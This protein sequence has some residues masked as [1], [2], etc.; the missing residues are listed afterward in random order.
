MEEGRAAVPK[1]EESRGLAKSL[2]RTSRSPAV[3]WYG[4]SVSSPPVQDNVQASTREEAVVVVVVV[5]WGC[6]LATATFGQN[7]VQAR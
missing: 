1:R 7:R 2:M 6:K 5:A 3:V 4:Y